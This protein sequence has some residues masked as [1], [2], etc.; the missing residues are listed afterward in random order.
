MRGAL[1]TEAMS[2]DE[3]PA[4]QPLEDVVT[5]ENEVV[6][7][8]ISTFSDFINAIYCL[9]KLASGSVNMRTKSLL[10]KSCNSPR[11]GRRP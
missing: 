1:V 11:I 6:V 2:D 9:T 3:L 7:K 8:T 5:E 4:E 10:F